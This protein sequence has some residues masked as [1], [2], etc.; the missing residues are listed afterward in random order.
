[1]YRIL[2]AF[3]VAFCVSAHG[4]QSVGN[5]ISNESSAI[6]EYF[7]MDREGLHIHTNKAVYLSGEKIWMKGYVVKKQSHLPYAETMNVYVSLID[8]KGQKVDN[9]LLYAEN[10]T[11]SGYIPLSKQLPGG[12]YYLQP[13]TNYMNN[14]K[15]DES[16]I[17]PITVLGSGSKDF[18]DLNAI[19]FNALDITFHP[20]SGVFLFGTTNTIALRIA[21]CTGNGVPGIEAQILDPNGHQVA[22]VTTDPSGYA[23]FD[24]PETQMGVYKLKASI[25]GQQYEKSLPTPAVSGVTF[26]INNYVFADKATVT[27]KTNKATLDQIKGKTYSFIIQQYGATTMANFSFDGNQ[28]KQSVSIPADHFSDGLNTVYLLDEQKN[29]IAERIVFKAKKSGVATSLSISQKRSDSIVVKGNTPLRMA[30]LSISILPDKALETQS[31]MLSKIEFSSLSNNLKLNGRQSFENFNRKKHFELDNMLMTQ[32][33]RYSWQAI[34]QNPPAPKYEFDLG[35]TVKGV[36]NNN[37]IDKAN[38]KVNLNSMV[39]GLNE[40]AGINEK[41]EFLFDRMMVEDSSMV[42]FSLFDKKSKKS[43]IKLTSQVS[44]NNR[45]YIKSFE[46]VAK[47]CILK[48]V[49]WDSGIPLIKGAIQ[50]DSVTVQSKTSKPKL[51]KGNTQRFSNA[52]SKGYKIS[53]EDVNMYT[54]VVDFIQNHGYN[55]TQQGGTISIT[56]SYS[57][58]FYSANRPQIFVD[59]ILLDDHNFLNTYRM[60]M[61]DEIY[62]NKRGYGGGMSGGAGF[63]RIYLKKGSFGGVVKIL[64]KGLTIKGGFQRARDFENEYQDI[65]DE[66]FRKL[67]AIHW[68]PNVATDASGD[69]TFSFP[70][71]FQDSVKVIIEGISSEGEV[72]SEVK[73]IPIR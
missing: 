40:F 19:D 13:Y 27:V 31:D 38:S 22:T 65:R 58:S 14:F 50:L 33:S 59:D 51:E 23:R 12:V 60:D 57:T 8:S 43:E 48:P 11:F 17:Y 49:V 18:Y 29:K 28:T 39:L 69:F 72:I 42:Y 44:G 46:P 21:D 15:E 35:L 16:N 26:S 68:I 56:R 32:T 70:N 30:S 41:G 34:T 47:T 1:M 64:S 52:M 73:I 66:S 10:S 53:K 6:A 55:V 62:I 24:I 37:G 2:L 54:T 4:Q 9:I 20:E 5:I 7:K 63:I 67:G 71:F 36:V 25:R 45:L 3:S 61:V